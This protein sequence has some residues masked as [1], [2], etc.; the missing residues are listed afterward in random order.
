MA[1]ER[2]R[3]GVDV[4]GTFTDLVILSEETGLFRTQKV[5]STPHDPSEAV[6]G[7]I[8]RAKDRLGVDSPSVAHLTHGTTVASN[9]ILEG[10]GARTGLLTTEGFRDVLEI[11]RHKRYELFNLKYRK[12]PPLVPRRLALGIPERL[13]SQGRVVR[14]LDEESLQEALLF[15]EAEG[16]E[17][18]AICFLFSFVD[19]VHEQRAAELARQAL[20]RCYVTISSEVF[21]QFREYER[22]STT[23]VNAY[24]GP[25]ISRYLERMSGEIGKIGIEAPLH[26]MQS[27]GG[28]ITAEEAK[29]MPV[30]IVESGPAAGVIAAAFLG[31]L[32]GKENLL[33]FDMGGTTAKAG[34]IQRGEV[35]QTVGHEVGG[36]INISRILQG[37]GYYVGAPSVDLAEVSAGGGSIA[38][39][40]HGE[41]LKVGPQS[42]G[43]NPGPICYGLGG[44]DITIT[45]SNVLLGRINSSYFLGGE[46]LLDVAK[47]RATVEKKLANPLGFTVEEA[48]IGILDVANANMLNLLRIISVEK[49]YDPRDFAMVAFG[50]AGPLHA[51]R[52]AEE[53]G[54]PAII[55]PPV[56]GLFS[57]LGLLV[58]DIRYDFRQTHVCPV[59]A[60]DL[61]KVESLYETLEAQGRT[62][63]ARNGVPN[64]QSVIHRSADVRY[65]HQAYEIN[66]PITS[67]ALDEKAR[68]RIVETF[69]QAHERLY[70]RSEQEAT[71]EF[72]NLCVGAIGKIR[73]PE[74]RRLPRQRGNGDRALKPSRRVFFRE[75]GFLDCPC[76]E[77]NLLCAEN[78]LRGP[79]LI[80]AVDSTVVIPPTWKARCDEFGNLVISR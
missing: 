39:L 80:E 55:I 44:D 16:I 69:H 22:A 70:G 46:M 72:V 78:E 68:E 2:F 19:R 57:A 65:P 67:G 26:I 6:L 54:M 32:I 5:P 18:L 23:V 66:I 4:G 62:A 59:Q 12:I 64:G 35:R 21:P 38:W 15:L 50:G 58:A 13:D 8:R 76:Y 7:V 20:P 77:R 43:A 17:A 56:P 3:L 31:G 42:A 14:E 71:V 60:A 48:C 73:A 24:L 75:T 49:G 40:D 41:V 74:L 33:S 11:A 47:T 52:L 30:R 53:L 37:G 10:S 45:D 63:L 61:Q 51:V 25:K 79:A 36:G 27:N 34:L 28:I 9:T 1:S 29:R